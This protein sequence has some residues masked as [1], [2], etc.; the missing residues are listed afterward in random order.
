MFTGI[1]AALGTIRAAAP[2]GRGLR[3]E[4]EHRLGEEPITSGESIACDGC[5]LTA[6]DPLTGRF[7]AELSPETLTRTGGATRWRR[8]RVLNLE[9]AL[10]AGDRLGGH[11]VQGHA[12]GMVRL[13]AMR[14]EPG[15]WRTLRVQLPR[16]DRALTVEKGSIALD[17]VSLTIARLGTTWFEVAL[18]PTTVS[19]TT[20]G[21]RR[22][23]D[24]LIVEYELF[25][26]YSSRSAIAARRG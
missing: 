11:L 14:T 2:R 16:A 7:G 15:G 3:I 12:D 26:K 8:G 4:I 23:G 24:R 21:R 5:C 18:I 25:A 17:G 22:P 1:I 13:L 10:R 20:L 6:I 9:R 19:Q